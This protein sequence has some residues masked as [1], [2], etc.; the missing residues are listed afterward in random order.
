MTS[1]VPFQRAESQ[2]LITASLT[3]WES[4]GW[5]RT[6][7]NIDSEAALIWG[8]NGEFAWSALGSTLLWSSE[9]VRTFTGLPPNT[10]V[11][12]EVVAT[13]SLRVGMPGGPGPVPANPTPFFGA[14]VQGVRS[15]SAT[16]LGPVATLSFLAM[17]DGSGGLEI[18]LGG[19]GMHGSQDIVA[20]FTTVDVSTVIGDFADII[21]DSAVLIVNGMQLTIS[22]GSWSF[23]PGEEWEDFPFPGRTMNVKGC[24]ELVRLKPTIKGSAMMAGEVQI[25][26][27]RPDGTWT[28]HATIAGARTFTP[29]ALRAYL[30]EYLSNVFIVWKRLRGDYIAVEFP[31]AVC[32]S[33]SLGSQDNDE[34]QFPLVIEAVQDLSLGGTTKTTVPY[35]LHTLPADTEVSD[36]PAGSD[37]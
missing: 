30:G 35:R 15:V 33:Y 26:A 10:L 13:W 4:N 8:G 22:R 5:V 7:D 36:L 23:D 37:S 31:D 6:D 19:V 34:G 9:L 17:T 12:V 25:S 21:L 20:G 2:P 1:L 11:R 16:T 28:D 32:G 27:Y 14:T 29:N 18:R 3:A 24:R